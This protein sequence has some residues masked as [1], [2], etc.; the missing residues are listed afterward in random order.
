MTSEMWFMGIIPSIAIIYLI[1]KSFAIRED[2][3]G[4]D[5]WLA[6]IAIWFGVIWPIT[7]A[8]IIGFGAVVGFFWGLNKT[9]ACIHRRIS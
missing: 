1:L 7:L 4:K 8:M 5:F 3:Q 9:L 2:M 6:V